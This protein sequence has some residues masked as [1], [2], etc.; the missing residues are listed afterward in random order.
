MPVEGV[1][2]GQTTPAADL[3]RVRA[4]APTAGGKPSFAALL[5]EQ[6][7]EPRDEIAS[8]RATIASFRGGGLLAGAISTDGLGVGGLVPRRPV[9]LPQ[10]IAPGTADPYGWR[11]MSRSMGDQVVAPGFGA[12]FERQIQQES[13]F[14]PDVVVGNR[15]ST[16]GAE[17]IAQLMPQYYPDV[18]RIDPQAG[19]EAGARTMRH[20]LQT[21]NGDVRKALASYNSG[22]GNVQRLVQTYGAGW[23]R[24]LP[25]ETRQYLAAILG[26]TA[27]NVPVRGTANVFGGSGPGGVL[28]PPLGQ[29]TAARR[30]GLGTEWDASVG[31]LVRSPADGR[32]SGITGAPADQ[33]V[34]IDHGNGWSSTLSGLDALQVDIGNAVRRAEP[35]GTLGGGTLGF[36]LDLNGAALDPMRYLL[37]G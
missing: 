20:Y 37:A 10:P 22:L 1:G 9:R 14:D 25:D 7:A 17:G 3:A 8:V 26:D 34:R 12:I 24:G 6:L 18:N 31:D 27:P 4:A 5:Q 35:L 21:F 33:T 11:A 30:V 16:A 19:L 15:R 29:V 36:G 13:G 23:E 28:T 2:T 32:V